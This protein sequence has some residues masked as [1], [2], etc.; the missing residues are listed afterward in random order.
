MGK[1]DTV[2][3]EYIRRPDIFADVFNQFL[4]HG[5]QVIRPGDLTELDTTEIAVPYGIDNVS[6]PEQRYRD[7]TKFLA[8]MTD[9]KAAYCI[10]GVENE[11]KI[12]YAM[13]VK[14]GLY[15]FMQLAKQVSEI[16]RS[17]KKSRDKG[18]KPSGDEF[19]SGF[20]KDDKLY[21]VITVVVY[22]GANQWDGSLSLKEMYV[23]CDERILKYATDYHVNLIA[24]SQLSDEEI[25]EFQT[26]FREVMKYMKY[27]KDKEKLREVIGNDG[28]FKNLERQ[29][30]DV[31]STVS[32]TTRIRYSGK[33]EKVNMCLAVEEMMIESVIHA[34]QKRG[35]P[36]EDTKQ[37]IMEEYNRSEEEAEKLI[38]ECEQ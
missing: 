27:S 37:Y 7:V 9:G 2:T 26:N 8:A 18:R 30:A 23:D 17:H 28:R 14:D 16:A 13:P 3:K 31:I 11:D 21:P 6:V 38:R 24:P 1:P 25:D 35:I 4:Y 20:W 15:D 36:I 34:D 32:G 22:Y 10:L 5:E 29:A 19:L 33:E 12:N